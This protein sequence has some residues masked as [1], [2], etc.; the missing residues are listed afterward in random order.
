MKKIDREKQL[1]IRIEWIMGACLLLFGALLS[2]FILP[3]LVGNE[4]VS[5]WKKDGVANDG[6]DAGE[7]GENVDKDEARLPLSGIKIVIDPGHG[8]IDPGKVGVH[9]ELEKDIN[10]AISQKLAELL[11]EEGAEIVC[12]RTTDAGLYAESDSNKKAA[13]LRARCALI[14]AEQ[15][16]ITIS[17]HQNSYTS[18]SIRGAQ[19]FYYENSQEGAILAADLQKSLIE[20]A[21]PGNKR[22]QKPNNS[23]YMLVHSTSP[24][25]IVECGFLSNA[26]EA[27]KLTTEVYQQSIAKAIVAGVK[28]YFAQE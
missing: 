4:S 5:T 26:D 20:I 8:G 27:T 2:L 19:V 9:D 10:L 16:D 3:R 21:D 28:N 12:T 6:N 15:P 11:E 18:E 7:N 23:Y 22:V 25:V 24:T 1:K 14:A 17:V 13:D